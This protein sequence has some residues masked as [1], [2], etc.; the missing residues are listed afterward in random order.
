M[1]IEIP[2]RQARVLCE[3]DVL[4]VGGGPAGVGA[5]VAAA[6][7]GCDAVLLEKR[8][9][10]GGNITASY[11]ETCNHFMKGTPFEARGI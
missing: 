7:R 1:N 2:A 5:A 11:V 10:L 6:E 3:T 4:V 9:F 8:G